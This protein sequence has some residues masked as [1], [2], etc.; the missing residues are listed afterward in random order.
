MKCSSRLSSFLCTRHHPSVRKRC[1]DCQPG[2]F[3]L[4]PSPKPPS[5]RSRHAATQRPLPPRAIMNVEKRSTPRVITSGTPAASPVR[6]E[7]S[8][9]QSRRYKVLPKRRRV[10]T[11][12]GQASAL[13]AEPEHGSAGARFLGTEREKAFPYPEREVVRGLAPSL[14]RF[15]G[16]RSVARKG[17]SRLSQLS[18]SRSGFSP[19]ARG[20]FRPRLGHSRG[21]RLPAP[22]GSKEL[23]VLP[24]AH[25]SPRWDS[26]GSSRPTHFGSPGSKRRRRRLRGC[27]G[28]PLLGSENA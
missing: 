16:K 14:T 28:R 10:H 9:R 11:E 25:Q 1:P 24:Q 6:V 19:E 12:G 3:V 21:S 4:G 22:A 26:A 8:K 17:S 20:C 18:F 15:T 23:E 27:P 2:T 13:F 5:W 7:S